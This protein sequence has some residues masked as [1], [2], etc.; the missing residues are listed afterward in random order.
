MKTHT[1][2]GWTSE[3]AFDRRSE[4]SLDAAIRGI[5]IAP[6]SEV[7]AVNIATTTDYSGPL[8]EGAPV[9]FGRTVTRVVITPLDFTLGKIRLVTITDDECSSLLPRHVQDTALAQGIV[10]LPSGQQ[11]SVYLAR[12]RGAS[13]YVL[14][15][16]VRSSVAPPAPTDINMTVYA[17]RRRGD[18]PDVIDQTN[19]FMS[20]TNIGQL[21][22]AGGLFSQ[23][24]GDL[25]ITFANSSGSTTELYYDFRYGD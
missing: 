21:T 14:R 6:D 5:A 11:R 16:R 22:T 9:M 19:D 13:A 25:C 24:P 23:G 10:S 15:F 7:R 12:P 17:V 4:I 2:R 18:V 20:T 1:L 8:V 3:T